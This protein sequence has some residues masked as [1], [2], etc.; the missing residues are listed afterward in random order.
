M[1]ERW[2]GPAGGNWSP[3]CEIYLHPTGADYAKTTGKPGEQCGHSTVGIKVGRVVSRRIDLR[4][5]ESSLLDGALPYEVTQVLV[6]DLFADQPIPRW[7]RIGMAA[8]S[9][10]P[11]SVARYHRAVPGLLR[12]KKLF[13]IGPFL[14]QAEFPDAG[15]ITPFYA[16]SV[17][18][19]SYL[20]QLK[21]PKAFT[22][23]LREAPRRG[24]AKAITTHYGFKDAA[25]L[26]DHWV[27]HSLGAE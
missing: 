22:A 8:L 17:S 24:F 11:E 25:E 26:Q 23:F 6:G 5:D 18:L 13:A 1:Y 20:V 16:E 27:K 7:A 19:V 4:A 14:D 21:G 2:A 3:R 15:S 12:D 9:E 10:S